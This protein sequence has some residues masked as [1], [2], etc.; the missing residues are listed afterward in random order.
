MDF[1]LEGMIPHQNRN[2][3]EANASPA[4]PN[5]AL[6]GLE[7]FFPGSAGFLQVLLCP[8]WKQPVSD[9][10]PIHSAFVS[11]KKTPTPH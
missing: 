5:S 6:F 3:V 2:G 8:G 11:K 1:Q 10:C 7:S 4:S 9:D